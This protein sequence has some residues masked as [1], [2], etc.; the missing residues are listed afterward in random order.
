MNGTE[1]CLA[2]LRGK[3]P[4][5][6]PVI[7]HNFQMAARA[8]GITMGQF[9]RDPCV[10]AD[11]F[12]H[13]VERYGYDGVIVDVDTVTLAEAAG[14][15]V[16]LPEDAPARAH[17]GRLAGIREAR[18]LAPVDLRT[19]ERIGVWL[20]ACSILVKHFGGEVAI[21]GNCDQCP[22]TL[23]AMIRGMDAWMA[24]LLDPDIEED[25]RLLLEHTTAITS[26]FLMLMADTGVAVLSNGDSPAGTD[27]ISPRLYRSF[28]LPYE[29][30]IVATAHSLGKPYILHICGDTGPIVQDMIATGADGL[31]IDYKTDM[32]LAHRQMRDRTAFIGNI[33]P[34]GV[35]ALGTPAE[36]RT[37]TR[38]LLELFADTP[39]F[40][41][42][43]GCALPPDTP[44]ENLRAMITTAR[45]FR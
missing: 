24:E 13:A 30:R 16:D 9:R 6:V 17:R 26:Q 31:E 37:K 44:A 40:I 28:A 38:E 41:L 29:Q 32:E 23:A 1:R 8:D 5:K 20:E 34:S 14:V 27:M 15:P 12:I 4:D 11:A 22:Y 25:L 3:W 35:L 33:D 21:R 18:D 36:V 7:L 2:A 39:R 45:E 43:A 42:N 10:M 19:S